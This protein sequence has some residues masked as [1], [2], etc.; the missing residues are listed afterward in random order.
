MKKLLLILI[1]FASF[2]LSAQKISLVSGNPKALKGVSTLDVQFVYSDKLHIGKMTEA[3]YIAKHKK[4]ADAKEAGAGDKWEKAYYADRDEH[5]APKFIEL[6]NKGL[7]KKY[8]MDA[9]ENN[10]EA[11]FRMVV[12]TTFIEP[13]FNI[14]I[15][16]RPAYVNLEISFVNI[17]TGEEVAKYK[18]QKSP[19][20]A[21]YDLGVRVGEA[22]A[23]GAKYF[24]K[25]L[26]KKKVF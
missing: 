6:F 18:I 13:G 7:E 25:F 5:F 17:E 19:G 14:G 26:L 3:D 2:Q 16:S 10:S 12:T 4:E 22:Y 24:A 8:G 1:T 20:T 21:Y 15:Q 11:K 23:K 9:R